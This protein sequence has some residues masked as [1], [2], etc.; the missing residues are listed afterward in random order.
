MK[1]L[2][3]AL[4]L[5]LLLGVVGDRGY[6]W[7]RGQIYLPTS[8][9]SQ[10]VVVTLKPGATPQDVGAELQAGG[11]IRNQWLFQG[12]L[13]Y[14]R[15]RGM[16]PEFVAGELNRNMSMAAIVNTLENPAA[17]ELTVRLGEGEPLTVLAQQAA[18][19]GVGTISDYTLAA[20]DLS[21]WHYDFLKGRPTD[22]P[23]NLEGFL[24]PDTY[25][26]LRGAKADNLIKRQLDRF[27][28][29]LTPDLRE[30]ISRPTSA[31]AAMTV[32]DLIILASIVDREV[33]QASDRPIVCDVFFNRLKTNMPLGSDATVL[34]ALG[35]ANGT[36]SQE[37]L[38]VNS[39]YNTRNHPGLPPGPIANP[40]LD[41]IKACVNAPKTN[42]YYFFTDQQGAT[43]Y[44]VTFEEFLRQ[45][46]QYKL[47]NQ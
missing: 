46:K 8:N 7:V 2:A 20:N 4:V 34:Y 1:K 19:Q 27:G 15:A 22:A 43:H 12:Y 32:Y 37:D 30:A 38:K 28:R 14:L 25:Q 42:Y 3:V 6:E 24:F 29:V 13:R 44:A 21:R 26:V 16:P 35:R 11:L 17:S 9:Q 41:A 36:L 31:R 5:L 39:P 10:P 45:L 18:K 47:A 33:N 23:N 40:G